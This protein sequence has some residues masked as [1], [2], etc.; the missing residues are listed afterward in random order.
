MGIAGLLLIPFLA[1]KFSEE[2]TWSGGDFVLMGSLLV[3]LA[4]T[5]EVAVQRV[6]QKGYR[7]AMI[8]ALLG[9]F[10]LFWVNGAVGII[11]S[12]KQPANLLYGVVFAVGLVGAFLSRLRAPGLARTLWAAAGVQLLIP[13]VAWLVWPQLSWGAA[14]VVGVLLL[15][16][17]F[18]L[19]FTGAGWLFWRVGE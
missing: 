7:A 4:V 13:A 10:L 14:G 6:Q 19:F 11:G 5:Y 17:V 12:E 3:G 1:T 2:V 9:A 8:L 16:T 18:A 15:N